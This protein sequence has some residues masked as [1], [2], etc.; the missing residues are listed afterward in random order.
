MDDQP[1]GRLHRTVSLLAVISLFVGTLSAFDALVWPHPGAAIV[2]T[3]GYALALVLAVLTVVVR[4]RRTML[5]VDI[6]IL[7]TALMIRLPSWFTS[8][9]QTGFRYHNDE[10]A[11]IDFGGGLLRHG[12]NPYASVWP[13]GH[14]ANQPGITLTLT[15]QVV[16]RF[17]YPPLAAVWSALADAVRPGGPSAAIVSTAALL[18]ATV[19]LFVLLPAPWRS[20][21]TLLMIGLGVYLMPFARQGYPEIMALP[22]LI[23]A[24]NRWTRIGV[25]GRLG[26]LG[27]TSALA[28]GLATCTQQMSWFLVPFLVVGLLL[29]RLGDGPA[30]AAWALVGRYAAIVVGVFVV[31]NLPFVIWG[32]KAWFDALWTP[33]TAATV[34]HGQGLVDVPY[35]L[36]GGSGALQFLGYASMVFA[37]ALLLCFALFVRRLGPAMATLPWLIFFLSARSSDKYFYIMMP[38]WFLTLATVPLRDFAT[39]YEPRLSKPVRL[40]IASVAMVPTLAFALIAIVTPQPLRL[41]NVRVE[42]TSSGLTSRIQVE[43][44]NTSGT[45]LAPHFA[46]SDSQAFSRFWVVVS[47][48]PTLAP[49][50]SAPYL[51]QPSTPGSR[52]SL[53]SQRLLLRATSASPDTISSVRIP[54]TPS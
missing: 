17:D 19:L 36:L 38:L 51:L 39:A 26:A 16:D 4:H 46:L 49:G 1:I 11:L 9:H 28:L 44:E 12:M 43:V 50:Q 8:F 22:F 40:T 14:A 30:R 15:G 29:V 32:P 6:G 52:R 10:G 2:I 5:G 42:A 18:A 37:V 25:D 54:T 3:S 33:L 53:H 20:G 27:L 45:A 23:L 41:S 31:V 35:Y 48:P 24:V 34:P 47:G 13:G 21:A 7:I